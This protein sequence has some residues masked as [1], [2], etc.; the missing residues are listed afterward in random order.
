MPFRPLYKTISQLS[1][2]LFLRDSHLSFFQNSS[3]TPCFKA[4]IASY[5]PS[6]PILNFFSFLVEE[7]GLVD[8]KHSCHIPKCGNLL[9]NKS[10][11]CCLLY[12][13]RTLIKIS[14]QETKSSICLSTDVANMDIP[15]QVMCDCYSWVFYGIHIF[16][17]CTL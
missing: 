8:P 11:I 10:F 6:S 15:S 4:V 17:G 12:I 5:K 14:S 9:A 7:P 3:H 1:L 2:L 16:E 13:L